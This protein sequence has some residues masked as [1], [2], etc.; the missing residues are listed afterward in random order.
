MIFWKVGSCHVSFISANIPKGIC[1]GRG[2]CFQLILPN[3]KPYT[4]MD[5]LYS[6]CLSTSIMSLGFFLFRLNRHFFLFILICSCCSKLHSVS[7]QNFRSLS[8][9]GFKV[10]KKINNQDHVNFFR[11]IVTYTSRLLQFHEKRNLSLTILLYLTF[12]S[13]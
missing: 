12:F 9:S 10:I 7:S 4:V 3:A 2:G 5:L 1:G 11:E 8:F 13:V 6:E